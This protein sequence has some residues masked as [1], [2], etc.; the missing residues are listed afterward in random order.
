MS[1][2]TKSPTVTAWGGQ[3]VRRSGRGQLVQSN[4]AR[5][6]R[7]VPTQEIRI[8]TGPSQPSGRNDLEGVGA[9]AV[10]GEHGEIIGELLDQPEQ[11]D[12]PQRNGEPPPE[13][14]HLLEAP[15]TPN[16]RL[17]SRH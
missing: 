1:N 5:Q 12:R 11:E 14:V 6:A 10:G 15:S 17:T 4:K 16:D 3:L 8:F 2:F 7:L 13:L 9:A